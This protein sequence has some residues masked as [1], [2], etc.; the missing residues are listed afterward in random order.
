MRLIEAETIAEAHERAIKEI[1]MDN[2]IQ[3]TKHGITYEH[4]DGLDIKIL[5]PFKEPLKSDAYHLPMRALDYYSKQL[6]SILPKTNSNKDFDY[7]CGNRWY[8]YF[9]F[10]DRGQ[11][12]D[13]DSKGF[14]QIAATIQELKRDPTSRRAVI[15]SLFPP[16]DNI[17]T[18]IPCIS[19]LQFMLRDERLNLIVY[20]RSND[21]LSAWGADAYAL[22]K[23]LD[24]VSLMLLKQSGY[25]EIISVSAHI[26]FERDTEELKA[27]RRILRY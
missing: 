20:I 11:V 4:P 26:Y 12:G 21:M 3:K 6:L 25:L 24:Y 1:L 19:M 22:S 16:V 8:D 2:I 18:H 10:T 15:C 7:N 9:D 14:N 17:K 13:G 5:H 27:F 23:V